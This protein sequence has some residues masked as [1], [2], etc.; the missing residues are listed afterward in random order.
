MN[1][2]T[3]SISSMEPTALVE[4]FQNGEHG[5]FDEMVDRYYRY[6][7]RLAYHFTHNPEDAYDICQEVFVKVFK[8]LGSL[9][10]GSTLRTWLRRITVNAC[11]DCR[12]QQSKKP[13]M[14]DLRDMESTIKADIESPDLPLEAR[15]LRRAISEAVDQLP[16]RQKQT[17]VLRYYEDLSLK[18]V[19]S[20]LECPLGTVKA[21]LFHATQKLR[22]LL[23]PY[24]S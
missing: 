24:V 4:R 2:S 11:I 14:C 15:E 18:E 8:S 16:R 13:I 20:A 19:A 9:R 3:A 6:V 10:N 1:G 5:V 22:G 12:R 21:N 23:L 17:F 7:Y